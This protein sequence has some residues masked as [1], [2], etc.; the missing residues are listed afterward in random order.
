MALATVGYGVTGIWPT[1][2]PVY[3]EYVTALLAATAVYAGGNIMAKKILKDS[4]PPSDE[5][6]PPSE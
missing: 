3:P 1:L 6:P 2:V 5:P 4:S